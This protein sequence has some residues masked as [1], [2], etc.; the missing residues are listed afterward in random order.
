MAA[1]EA[2]LVR[3]ILPDL[4]EAQKPVLQLCDDT[5]ADCL[6]KNSIENGKTKYLDV[7]WHYCREFFANG[8]LLVCRAESNSQLADV[9]S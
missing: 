7:H 6:L 1:D 3:K 2:I 8:K 9:C 5:A 4:G